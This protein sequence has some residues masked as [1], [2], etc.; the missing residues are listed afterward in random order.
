MGDENCSSNP[1]GNETTSLLAGKIDLCCQTTNGN[2]TKIKESLDANTTAIT[3]CCTQ[4][5]TKMTT[6]IELLTTISKK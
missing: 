4:V 2:L 1:F 3:N 5:N 6:I